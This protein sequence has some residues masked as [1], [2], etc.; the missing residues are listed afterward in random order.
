MPMVS[1]APEP[2]KAKLLDRVREA[3]R[4][5]HYSL[6]T[7]QSYIDW[8]KRFIIFHAKQGGAPKRL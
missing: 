1:M 2:G 6:R 3:I 5:K 7:E 8:I 4:F